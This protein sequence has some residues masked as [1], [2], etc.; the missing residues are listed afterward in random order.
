MR[1]P[2][3]PRAYL[4][5]AVTT[6]G[7]AHSKPWRVTWYLRDPETGKPQG[8]G[9]RSYVLEDSARA[10]EKAMRELGYSV[11]CWRVDTLPGL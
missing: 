2:P 6:A 3:L 9:R 1:A 4:A 10:H 5:A 11:E 7:K 8:G